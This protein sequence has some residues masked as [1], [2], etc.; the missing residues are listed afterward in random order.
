[1][2]SVKIKINRWT[3][4]VCHRFLPIVQYNRYQSNQIHRLLSIYQFLSIGYSGYI[5]SRMTKVL[6]TNGGVYESEIGGARV[7]GPGGGGGSTG[8]LI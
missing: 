5:T 3:I 6:V 8:Y 4:R 2:K 7:G 1:M